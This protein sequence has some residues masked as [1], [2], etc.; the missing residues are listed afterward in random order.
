METFV[1]GP[2][3]LARDEPLLAT[4]QSYKH[5]ILFFRLTVTSIIRP[6]FRCS[7]SCSGC[8]SN[9]ATKHKA[10]S[11]HTSFHRRVPSAGCCATPPSWS[12]NTCGA[13]QM[14]ADKPG[15]GAPAQR[16]PHIPALTKLSSCH[17][18]HTIHYNKCT[19]LL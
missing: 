13:R 17:S 15:G 18:F 5:L 12:H 1:L 6:K 3:L 7:P 14:P 4:F 16:T 10:L 2:K 8:A 11:H 19:E 9:L